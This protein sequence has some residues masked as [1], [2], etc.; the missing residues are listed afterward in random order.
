MFIELTR[1]GHNVVERRKFLA[2]TSTIKRVWRYE[3]SYPQLGGSILVINEPNKH[4]V[5]VMESYDQI[6]AAFANAGL[7]II[8]DSG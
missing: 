4:E 8:P 6:K 2:H 3:G 7:T 1:A 5:H